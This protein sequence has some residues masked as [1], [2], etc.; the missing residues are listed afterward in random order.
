MF[1]GKK[2]RQRGVE[3]VEEVTCAT[4]MQTR[5]APVWHNDSYINGKCIKLFRLQPEAVCHLYRKV[6]LSLLP[7]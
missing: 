2:W 1:P 6:N 3:E 4:I 5:W 7:T